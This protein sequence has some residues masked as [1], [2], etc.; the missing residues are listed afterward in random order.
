MAARSRR[1]KASRSSGH[2][3]PAGQ[4]TP[5]ETLDATQSPA[6]DRGAAGDPFAREPAPN[7]GFINIGAYGNTEQASKSPLAYVFVLAPN[8][9]EA[10]HQRSEFDIRWRDN[11]F[12]GTVDIDVSAAGVGGPFQTLAAGEANDGLFEWTVDPRCSPQARTTSSACASRADPMISDTSDFAFTILNDPPVV[13]NI[14]NVV[15]KEGDPFTVSVSAVDPEGGAL[16]AL[17]SGIPG[18]TAVR[19]GDNFDI[20]WT[21]TPDGPGVANVVLTVSDEGSP[22]RSV[23][24]TFQ[25]TTLNVAPTLTVTGPARLHK[26]SLIR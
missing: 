17:V 11:G 23:T 18:I 6:I 3:R 25:V 24:R 10:I 5:V 16:T 13:G 9:G 12:A 26:V 22:V 2:P 8:G 20:S 21:K 19:N 1:S 15:L 14:S 7:G 4:L